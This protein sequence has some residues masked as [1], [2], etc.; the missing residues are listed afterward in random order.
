MGVVC[1]D[2]GKTVCTSKLRVNEGK[3]QLV[4]RMRR[5]IMA[6]WRVGPFFCRQQA[7]GGWRQVVKAGDVEFRDEIVR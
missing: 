6:E 3:A 7:P 2:D 1:C 4:I 5:V